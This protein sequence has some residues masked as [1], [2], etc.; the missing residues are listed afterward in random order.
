MDI[1]KQN[2][3]KSLTFDLSNGEYS[4]VN[5]FYVPNLLNDPITSYT[6]KIFKFFNI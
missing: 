5:I 6:T 2:I 1:R 4:F 3:M